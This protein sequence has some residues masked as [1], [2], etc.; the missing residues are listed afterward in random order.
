MFEMVSR[1][2]LLY[3]VPLLTMAMFFRKASGVHI[4]KN[5]KRI[6]KQKRKVVTMRVTIV[7][8][9]AICWLP[10]NV[11]NFLLMFNFKV[12]S[13]LNTSLILIFYF[14]NHS[15]A[16][17][18]P[19]LCLVFNESFSEGFKHRNRSKIVWVEGISMEA[20]VFW[21]PE[22]K[23]LAPLHLTIHFCQLSMGVESTLGP[24]PTR[25]SFEQINM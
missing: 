8:L 11:N 7:T 5:E 13:C 21:P 16:V 3:L 10:A 22:L 23:L 18:N 2:V 14:L 12:H 24:Q 17:I 15:N 4:K 1:F 6:E 20:S 9:F 25:H 19:C